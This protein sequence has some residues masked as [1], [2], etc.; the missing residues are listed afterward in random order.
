MAD[1]GEGRSRRSSAVLVAA[2]VISTCGLI[3]ELLAGTLASYV[4]GDSVTQFSTI[5]GTYLFS[6]GIG[7]WLSRFVDR[8][9]V[10]RF[11][12]VETAVALIG[13]FSALLLFIAFARLAWFGVVL[14]GM[15][16]LIG[17]LVG[18]EIPL[19][20]RI[21]DEDLD[22]K[23]LVARVL[24]AD[25]LGALVASLAFPLFFV[26]QLGLIRSSLAV[27]ALNAA[28]AV[29]C[30]HAFGLPAGARRTWLRAQAYG[31]LLLLGAGLAASEQ[32]VRFSEQQLFSD[33]IVLAKTTPYQRIVITRGR[34][35][36]Q[37][38]ING[39][40]QF[41][42][43]DEHRY[44]EALVHPGVARL[45]QTGRSPRRVLVLGGG[46]GLA[47]REVLKHPD[48]EAVTLVDLDPAM[49][50][51]ATNLSILRDL[52]QD[53][54]HDPRVTVENADAFVWVDQS[55]G[56]ADYDLILVDFPDP[57]SY[58][59]GKLYTRLFYRRLAR[60]LAP[61]GVVVVQSTSPLYARGS[62]WTVVHT[63]EAAGYSTAPYHAT[64][65]SFGEWGY[66]LAQ[67][68]PTSAPQRLADVPMSYLDDA[69][70]P[71]LF[72]FPRD[73]SEVPTGIHR[74]DDQL[75]VR[76]YDD[77]WNRW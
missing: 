69:V 3:Y 32:L 57:N 6:M 66:V 8:R 7:A 68:E 12:E 63:L 33:P 34:V 42:S 74:L 13:G 38:F 43:V 29:W 73:M 59:V 54:L 61:G 45:V 15:T 48:I 30:T 46:D 65:P 22:L 51:L 77:E 58:A 47:V 28:V 75:L 31:V 16:G 72:R 2:F 23:E 62:F 67:R 26:P 55:Q 71:G 4:L 9:L 44:H 50:D 60:W 27:G 24:S 49:T 20:M 1:A 70:L 37:L 64:V 21:L 17:T 56:A 76:L 5:I 19:L 40:L 52:N 36:F 14:Y 39:A 35:G 25:Y 10:T 18:L 41:T 11:I 53:A